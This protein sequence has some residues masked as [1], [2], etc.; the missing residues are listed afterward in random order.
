MFLPSQK[1]NPFVE[2]FV[3]ICSR[4]P[5]QDNSQIFKCIIEECVHNKRICNEPFAHP[6]MRLLRT[7]RFARALRCALS[8]ARSL[9]HS[10]PSSW[11]RGI[12]MCGFS[13]VLD[14]CVGVKLPIVDSFCRQMISL[15]QSAGFFY[16][17]FQKWRKKKFFKCVQG[18]FHH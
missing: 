7:A 9:T 15:C 6:L 4:A 3:C 13:S 17:W 14:H 11:D 8:F 12:L 18:D 1:L 10:L 5:E 2:E 16:C